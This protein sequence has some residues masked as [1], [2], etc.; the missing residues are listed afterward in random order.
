MTINEMPSHNHNAGMKS[1]ATAPDTPSPAGAALTV[2][3]Q[4]AYSTTTPGPNGSAPRFM[5]P[6]NIFVQ[7]TGGGQPQTNMQP[8][9]TTRKCIAIT[10]VYPSRN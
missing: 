2:Q 7:P 3:S 9:L 6:A 10:G 1:V 8:Y 4:N 5:N